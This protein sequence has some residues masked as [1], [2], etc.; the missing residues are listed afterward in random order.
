MKF[1][2]YF[3]SGFG[4]HELNDELHVLNIHS[5][6]RKMLKLKVNERPELNEVKENINSLSPRH[7]AWIFT[8]I[9]HICN[10]STGIVRNKV[11]FSVMVSDF[12]PGITNLLGFNNVS[13]SKLSSVDSM[14]NDVSKENLHTSSEF[15]EDLSLQL[16]SLLSSSGVDF[17]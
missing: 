17:H 1:R 3:E 8:L 13:T 16:K 2:N 10:L 5:E 7:S 12:S 15:E 14:V 4:V 9:H 11:C 6:T